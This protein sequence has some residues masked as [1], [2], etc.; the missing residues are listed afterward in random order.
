M[1]LIRVSSVEIEVIVGRSTD[2]VKIKLST[3]S[4]FSVFLAVSVAR[5]MQDVLLLLYAVNKA[6]NPP[7][8]RKGPLRLQVPVPES[9]TF[10]PKISSTPSGSVA[11][12]DPSKNL[13]EWYHS[14]LEAL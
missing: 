2:D 6:R 10:K 12:N 3:N 4:T 7:R 5:N 11:Y 1:R 14:S 9:M 13:S 8:R